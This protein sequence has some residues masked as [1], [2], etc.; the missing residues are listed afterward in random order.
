MVGA[1][2]FPVGEPMKGSAA[3]LSVKPSRVPLVAFVPARGGSKGI[4]GKNLQP[5][6]GQPLVVHAIHLCQTVTPR[7]IVSTDDAAIAAV[8]RFNGAEV[9]GRPDELADDHATVDDVC[10]WLA[11]VVPQCAQSRLLVVQPT[12]PQVKPYD[13][14][15]MVDEFTGDAWVAGVEE[16]HIHWRDELTPITGR[17]NRQD[18]LTWPHREIGV[19]LYAPDHWGDHPQRMF[20]FRGPVVDIDTP[21]DLEAV[22]SD[23][24]RGTIVFRVVGNHRLGSGHLHRCLAL[25]ERLQHHQIGF[26]PVQ[27]DGLAEALIRKHGWTV[28]SDV[29]GADLIVNDCL[30]TSVKQM[31]G[32][33]AKAPVVALEDL[34]E[35]AD[36]ASRTI[37]DMYGWESGSR[38][39]VMRPEFLAVPDSAFEGG[40]VLVTFGGTDPA[41]LTE[42]VKNLLS[43][44]SVAW[45]SSPLWTDK[46]AA[47]AADFLGGPQGGLEVRVVEPPGRDGTWRNL[48]EDMAWADVVVTSGGRTVWEAM[49]ARRPIVA[50]L[51]N[52]RE[53]THTHLTLGV[54]VV[55][56]GLG[57]LVN[58]EQIRDTVTRL[59]SSP[60]LLADLAS[61][62]K[63]VVDGRGAARIVLECEQLIG[64][65]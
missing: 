54:G 56:L 1:A 46:Y 59:A 25:A 50:L 62:M 31:A 57:T 55:N 51:Q 32:L 7:V 45:G 63:G 5:V 2:C 23:M 35:G 49:A 60:L 52:V 48:A 11:T 22:R 64:G 44:T 21:A 14:L 15:R 26:V 40:K 18:R 13:L 6:A 65:L 36:L 19:R 39:V 61:R 30:D 10:R 37:N 47:K 34:G 4:R 38:W 3:S 17:G 58:D 9:V 8:A 12:V 29:G 20:P 27:S 24:E 53:T 28:W 43:Q 33:L 16:P 42:R 41:G